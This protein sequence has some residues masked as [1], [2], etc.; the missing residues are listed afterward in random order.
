MII[1]YD[2]SQLVLKS[3]ATGAKQHLA[4]NMPIGK[5]FVSAQVVNVASATPDQLSTRIPTN[6]AF[7]ILVFP[8]N[9]AE[10]RLMTRLKRFASWLDSPDSPVSKYTPRSRPRDSVIDVVTIREWSPWCI[11]REQETGP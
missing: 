6:G 4:P 2:E 5:R 1:N 8:G 9:V 3:E 11:I 7:R 10:P